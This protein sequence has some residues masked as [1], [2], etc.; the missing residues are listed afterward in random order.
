VYLLFEKGYIKIHVAVD[1]KTKQVVTL[2]VS[3]EKTHDREKLKPL[4]KKAQK[5]ARVKRVLGDGSYDSHE[6]FD[7]LAS[8]GIEPC[9]KVRRDSILLFGVV[10]LGVR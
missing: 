9:I 3:D 7:F 4:V 1:T 5:K 2:E 6:N 10:G 8:E